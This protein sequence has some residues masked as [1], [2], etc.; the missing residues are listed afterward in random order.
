MRHPK[1]P[2]PFRDRYRKEL[3]L[4]WDK[5]TEDDLNKIGTSLSQLI[6]MLQKHYEYTRAEA[7]E[8]TYK[9]RDAFYKIQDGPQAP[10][11]DSRVIE[12]PGLPTDEVTP[13]GVNYFTGESSEK[14][15]G[16]GAPSSNPR[17][18][19]QPGL[20]T[21]GVAPNVPHQHRTSVMEPIMSGWNH[22]LKDYQTSI[23]AT[24]VAAPGIM[25]VVT[26]VTYIGWWLDSD[27]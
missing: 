13:E 2:D 6:L 19:E 17:V 21:D 26:L 1:G 9:F 25:I 7:R 4:R 12:Q 11:L 8:E 18:I 3:K 15:E 23:S 14:N 27:H 22:F 20:P 16:P 24:A 5:L 10:S